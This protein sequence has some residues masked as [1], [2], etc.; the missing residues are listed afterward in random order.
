MKNS[1]QYHRGVLNVETRFATFAVQEGN[2]WSIV[3][4]DQFLGKTTP[5]HGQPALSV[6][7]LLYEWFFIFENRKQINKKDIIFIINLVMQF[8]GIQYGLVEHSHQYKLDN[9]H[10]P[11]D[12]DWLIKWLDWLYSFGGW[13]KGSGKPQIDYGSHLK[14]ITH[15]NHN[16]TKFPILNLHETLEWLIFRWSNF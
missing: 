8:H 1:W 15:T 10:K 12:K 14:L 16:N 3:Q 13:W 11:S 7:K 4:I 5:R 2:L 6:V 9:I